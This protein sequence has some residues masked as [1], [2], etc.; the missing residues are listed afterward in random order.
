MVSDSGNKKPKRLPTRQQHGLDGKAFTFNYTDF[1]GVS[2]DMKILD[3]QAPANYAEISEITPGQ[4]DITLHMGDRD[5]PVVAASW[6]RWSS[7]KCSL[8][9]DQF[10]MHWIEMKRGGVFAKHYTFDWEG[11]TYRLQHAKSSETKATGLARVLCTQFKV[12]EEDSG[13]MVALYISEA[14]GLK[15]GT[16]KLKPNLGWDFE[17][18]CVLA[19]ASWRD[20][21]RRDQPEG[22]DAGGG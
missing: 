1:S 6:Y 11:R 15:K 16:M 7:F 21:K 4:P 14:V 10:S 19:F 8:G 12:I 22:L 9:P 5:G 18:S 2:R 17:I 13:E 20:K 3:E